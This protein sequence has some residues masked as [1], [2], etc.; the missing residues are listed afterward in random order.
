M[1]YAGS[2][3]LSAYKLMEAREAGDKIKILF[4]SCAVCLQESHI[5]NVAILSVLLFFIFIAVMEKKM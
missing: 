2:N 4:F 5:A 1:L 3:Y